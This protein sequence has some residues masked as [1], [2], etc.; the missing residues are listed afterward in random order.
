MR[1]RSLF[2]TLAVGALAIALVRAGF[3]MGTEPPKPQPGGSASPPALPGGTQAAAASGTRQEAERAYALAYEDL[4]KAK[5]DAESGNKKGAEKKYKK[6]L[7]RVENAVYLDTTYHEAWNLVG[8][9]ARKLGNYEKAF[10]A[11]ERCLAIKPDYAAAREY[12][13]EAWL[14]KGDVK[15]SRLQLAILEKMNPGSDET[16]ALRTAIDAY[17]AAHPE[18]ALAAADSVAAPPDTAVTQT[19][20]K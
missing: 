2:A 17:A 8:Y 6:V 10:A 19:Q 18:A 1:I 9:A 13:G 12:L 20:N 15:K 4:A 5:K 16:K 11:Y 14:E 7:E 3:A